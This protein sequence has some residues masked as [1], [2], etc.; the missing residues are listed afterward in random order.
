VWLAVVSQP[1]NRS[2]T[3][4]LPGKLDDSLKEFW[5][6]NPWQIVAHGHNLSCYER[7]RVFLNVGGRDFLDISHLTAA[8][9]DGDGRA[10][11]AADFRNV[12]MLDLL[13]RQ[14]GGGALLLFENR[15]PRKNFL[16]VS[17]RGRASNRQGIGARLTAVI[18]GQQIVRELYPA[19]GYLSQAPNVVHFGLGDRAKI[20]SLTIRW[21]SGKLQTLTDLTGNR[22]VIV[23]EN[24]EG[25]DAVSTVTPGQPIAR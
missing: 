19:N 16:Q 21:P 12:G 5:V 2:A 7:N 15:L 6:D 4:P 23:D 11:V 18:N 25:A 20:D 3:V 1:C 10:V 13:V 17:L 24:N 9:S 14:A 8:D 22:H